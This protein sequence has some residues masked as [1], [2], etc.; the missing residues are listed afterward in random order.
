MNYLFD[1]SVLITANVQTHPKHLDALGWLKK[2]KFKEI[3]GFVAS[4]SLL[5]AYSVLTRA[6][7]KPKISPDEANSLLSTNIAPFVKFL[8]INEENYAELVIELSVHNFSGGIVYDALILFVAHKHT[9]SNIVT[10][11]EG[12][13][14]RLVNAFG[15]DIKIIG[16]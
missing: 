13:F 14:N 16:V 15:F 10:S 1:S 9:I 4:H 11:N 6:P 8:T 7:F 3:G 5:E 2:A 12:D